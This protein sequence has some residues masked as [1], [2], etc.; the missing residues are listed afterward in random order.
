MALVTLMRSAPEAAISD[1]SIHEIKDFVIQ[2]LKVRY[3]HWD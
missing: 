2:P 3:A 1:Q